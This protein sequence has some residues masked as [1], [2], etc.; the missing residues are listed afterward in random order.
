MRIL[1]CFMSG[2]LLFTLNTP[3]AKGQGIKPGRSA[4]EYPGHNEREDV[5]VGAVPLTAEQVHSTF[6][7]DLNRGYLVVELSIYP[8]AGQ[9][10]DV[11]R[12]DFVLRGADN[13]IVA[14]PGDP[15]AIASTLHRAN[16]SDREVA[17]YPS[18]GIGY[19]SGPRT[20]DPATGEQRGGGLRT[21]AGV[22]VGVGGSQAG[23]T[24]Q[25]RKTME[26]EL[27]EK[28]LP[29]GETSKPVAGYLY[30]PLKA[31]KKAGALRLEWGTQGEPILLKLSEEHP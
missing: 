20:Y 18:V 13:G 24:E 28:G 4:S 27:T 8:K 12:R 19:E 22:G 29:E 11:S 14:R 5:A 30:F 6:V 17:L 15:K 16:G 9:H 31:R 10:L 1:A 23:S 3:A 7:S 21:A 2:V 25:D 26:L